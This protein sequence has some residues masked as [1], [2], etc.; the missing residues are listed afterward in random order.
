MSSD[1]GESAKAL[2]NT[3]PKGGKNH[4]VLEKTRKGTGERNFTRKLRSSVDG[5]TTPFQ[6]TEEGA[7]L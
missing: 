4:S 6:P 5:G 2:I 1:G 3:A 7:A